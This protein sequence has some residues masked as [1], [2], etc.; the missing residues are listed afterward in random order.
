MTLVSL[1]VPPRRPLPGKQI[2]ADD[3]WI[4]IDK[5]KFRLALY[6]GEE[7]I[8]TWRIATSVNEGNKRSVGDYRTPTGT[9]RVQ[10]IE[11]AAGWTHD[12]RDGKGRIRGAYGPWFI[13]LRTGWA[14]IGIHGTHDPDSIGTRA[15]E[16]CLRMR[17]DHLEEL[18]AQVK[19]GMTVAIDE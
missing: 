3:L 11:N 10:S 8:R 9:F 12:F 13:R 19:V 16:G 4:H 17:N 1:D 5:G 7:P 6:R 2:K 15:T 14:G 18:K